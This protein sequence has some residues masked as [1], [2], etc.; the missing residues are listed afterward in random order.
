MHHHTKDNLIE[1]LSEYGCIVEATM[2]FSSCRVR[3]TGRG[4]GQF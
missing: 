4:W 2:I 3:W 1:S